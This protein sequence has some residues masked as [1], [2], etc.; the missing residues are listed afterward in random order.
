MALGEP[1]CEPR[2]PSP[3][4][5]LKKAQDQGGN[6]LTAGVRVHRRKKARAS[7][8]LSRSTA[9]VSGEHFTELEE[10]LGRVVKDAEQLIA[11]G[12][13]QPKQVHIC[14]ERLFDACCEFEI[15]DTTDL[16]KQ[17]DEN[18]TVEV[19]DW[20]PHEPHRW[21]VVPRQRASN[22]EARVA[23]DGLRALVPGLVVLAERSVEFLGSWRRGVPQGCEDRVAH[24][25]RESSGRVLSV[26][27]AGDLLC[28][29]Q[30]RRSASQR[31]A[32]DQLSSVGIF[33]IDTVDA[34][35]AHAIGVPDGRRDHTWLGRALADSLSPDAR[36]VLVA[37]L[38]AAV[39]DR[40]PNQETDP[41]QNRYER[42]NSCNEKRSGAHGDCLPGSTASQSTRLVNRYKERR[43][44]RGATDV[45]YS[46]KR[47]ASIGLADRFTAS[48]F[49][50]LQH[51]TELGQSFDASGAEES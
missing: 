20:D 15:L 25:W 29:G 39:L 31:Q 18:L 16:E 19:A 4:Q 8:E 40:T 22:R 24:V 35:C 14:V 6:F 26:E 5:A 21:E 48:P 36:S 42:D 13:R 27:A 23:A 7:G 3:G 9:A 12:G 43:Q 2:A 34:D 37:S 45:T 11:L 1:R 28:G 10:R 33:D 32:A 50:L 38:F 49:L 17:V 41:D 47:S 44:L 51:T 46:S 30:R